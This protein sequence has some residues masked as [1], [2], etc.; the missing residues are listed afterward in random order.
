MLIL[1]KD[2]KR[3]GGDVSKHTAAINRA[4]S[5]GAALERGKGGLKGGRGG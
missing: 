2:G 5:D 3:D 1:E 4:V